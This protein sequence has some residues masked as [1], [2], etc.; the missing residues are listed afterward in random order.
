MIRT[1]PKINNLIIKIGSNI[2]VG[3][4]NGINEERVRQIV[5]V[6]VRLKAEIPKITIVSSGAIAAGFKLLGFNTR[7]KEIIDKQACASVGQ[8]RLM[9]YYEQAFVKHNVHAAQILITKY[10]FS[11]RRRY[12]N[13]RA[14]LTRLLDLG[15][16]P[17]I[18]ENDAVVVNELKYVESFGDND[19]LS[20]LVAGLIEADM[21]LILSDVDGLY[22][23]NPTTDPTAKLLHN[24]DT[25]D[26]DTMALAGGAESA[27]G[28]GG[29]RSKLAAAA[30]ALSAGAYVAI[31][32][33]KEPE[34]MEKFLAGELVG[35]FFSSP[36]PSADRKKLWLSYATI[37]Q[38]TLTVD[39]GAKIALT[40]RHSSLL[41]SGVIEVNGRFHVGDVVNVVDI[42]GEPI[43]VGK[44]R[45][46]AE[47]LIKIKGLK[48]ADVGKRL[49]V[50][51]HCD[52]MGLV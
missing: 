23:A 24:I 47:E 8:A 35:T 10:D 19:N 52:E 32:N 27:V 41:P 9:W 30:K 1:L 22:T 5:N 36:I 26:S 3:D 39:D 16:I 14:T 31:L 13:A 4:D 37:P 18:N 43:A 46:S 34:N 38:G 17:I 29:M 12:L 42:E 7:P 45:Y 51:I 50:V 20:A 25:L 6:I 40:E 49:S 44:I 33:G 48:S 28:T 21:L 2:L 11:N 15:A